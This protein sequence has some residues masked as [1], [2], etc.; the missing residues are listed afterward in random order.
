MWLN[1]FVYQVPLTVWPF[2]LAAF[3]SLVIAFLTLS[4]Q[5]LK[6]ARTNPVDTLREAG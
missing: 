2:L 5:T 3:A 6:A 4:F 1:E